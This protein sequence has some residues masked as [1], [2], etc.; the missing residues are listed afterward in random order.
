MHTYNRNDDE[1]IKNKIY[2]N[3][4]LKSFDNNGFIKGKS[5]QI[6]VTFICVCLTNVL[7]IF[8]ISEDF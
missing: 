3:E 4:P 1:R 2:S 5:L 6:C 7:Y 8:N